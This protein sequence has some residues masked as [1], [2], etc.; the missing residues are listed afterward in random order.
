[1]CKLTQ[2]LCN[3]VHS[4]IKSTLLGEGEGVVCVATCTH[5]SVIIMRNAN[6]E[7]TTLSFWKSNK[8]VTELALYMYCLEAVCPYD[9]YSMS[10]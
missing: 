7:V 1:M 6:N 9:I 8:Y 5:W 10:M 4:P 2:M 3:A